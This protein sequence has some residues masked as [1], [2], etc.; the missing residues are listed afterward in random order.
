MIEKETIPQNLELNQ[1]IL[2][3]MEALNNIASSLD[4]DYKP[5]GELDDFFYHT[6]KG[7]SL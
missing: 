4:D 3:T 6:L 1:W 2:D 5:W 7:L